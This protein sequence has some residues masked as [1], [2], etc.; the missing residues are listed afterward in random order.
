MDCGWE[1]I[2]QKLKKLGRLDAMKCPVQLRN[3]ATDSEVS[4]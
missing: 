3:Y 2:Y 4:K 1:R